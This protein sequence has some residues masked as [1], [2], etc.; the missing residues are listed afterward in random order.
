[1]VTRI[2]TLPAF[3]A[4][5]IGLPVAVAAVL[6]A[7]FR[8]RG[9]LSAHGTVPPARPADRPHL[10]RQQRWHLVH[11]PKEPQPP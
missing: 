5:G 11:P 8:R 1:M 9:W 2:T 3:L 4:A 10:T 6:V 7:V